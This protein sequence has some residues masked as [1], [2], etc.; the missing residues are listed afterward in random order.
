MADNEISRFVASFRDN[1]SKY[2]PI[3]EEI[4]KFPERLKEKEVRHIW[5]SRIKT[6]ESLELKLIKRRQE[7]NADTKVADLVGGRIVLWKLKDFDIVNS[8]L[9]EEFDFNQRPIQHPTSDEHAVRLGQRFR[10]YD[11]LHF[12][13]RLKNS[14]NSDV[15]IEIQVVHVIMWIFHEVEHDLGYKGS[16]ISK[17]LHQNL[18]VLKGTANLN[19][20]AF[21][22]FEE[23]LEHQHGK[24][25]KTQLTNPP[26]YAN[27]SK[28]APISAN[29]NTSIE[30]ALAANE[31]FLDT[32]KQNLLVKILRGIV[33][34][35]TLGQSSYSLSLLFSIRFNFVC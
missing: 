24:G 25:S 15:I 17:E 29:F 8:L 10:G 26:N 23:L 2:Q 32:E 12:R 34:N 1:I 11:G 33:A 30:K 6:P 19:A 14:P 31:I 3:K 27:I 21:E 9:R 35:A 22:Q 16:S 5:E 13:L 18:E 4:D 7:G 20:L 28:T